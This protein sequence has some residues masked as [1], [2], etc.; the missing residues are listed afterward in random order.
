MPHLDLSNRNKQT[1][2]HGKHV[3]SQESPRTVFNGTGFR[4]PD[5]DVHATLNYYPDTTLQDLTPRQIEALS[6]LY[7]AKTYKEVDEIM[8]GYKGACAQLL[9]NLKAKFGFP[10]GYGIVVRWYAEQMRDTV[11]LT[12]RELQKL[13]EVKHG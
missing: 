11:T 5:R 13:L 3:F 12:G 1:G 10:P 6:L 9:R 8:F 2:I 7:M 4:N